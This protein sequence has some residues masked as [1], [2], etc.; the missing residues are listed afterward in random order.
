[1]KKT[2][3]A[4]CADVILLAPAETIASWTTGKGGWKTDGFFWNDES[5]TGVSNTTP[6]SGTT[7]WFD[8]GMDEI[9]ADS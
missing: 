7:Y 9:N 1:M 2:Y 6:A 3:I 5:L 8:F 4:P